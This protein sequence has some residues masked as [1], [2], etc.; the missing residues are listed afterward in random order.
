MTNKTTPEI[1]IAPTEEAIRLRAYQIW[2][3]EGRPEGCDGEHWRR[4]QAELEAEMEEASMAGESI[5]IVLPRLPISIPPKRSISAKADL[6]DDE[7]P[8]AAAGGGR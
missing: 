2:E 5:D 8:L 6:G 1:R 7:P 4:A 3:R